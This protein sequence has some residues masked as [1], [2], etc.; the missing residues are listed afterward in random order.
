[1]HLFYGNMPNLHTTKTEQTKN[2]IYQS[3]NCFTYASLSYSYLYQSQ[4]KNVRTI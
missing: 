1:M 2:H 4:I 3:E